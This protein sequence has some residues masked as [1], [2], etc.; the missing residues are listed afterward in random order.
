[1]SA[2]SPQPMIG[3][4]PTWP[5][6]L[7]WCCW[8]NCPPPGS[9]PRRSPPRR[10]TRVSADRIG[11]FKGRTP[12]I[13]R[14]SSFVLR[15]SS[16][17]P[18]PPLAFNHQLILLAQRDAGLGCETL[19]AGAHQG[20]RARVVQARGI[21][22]F[23]GLQAMCVTEATAP[24][25]SVRPSI[26]PASSSTTP[27]AVQMRAE[28]GVEDWV[29]L[30]DTHSSFDRIQRRST[31][32][33][34]GPTGLGGR[35]AASRMIGVKLGGPRAPVNND[36][37]W[38]VDP[39]V[40][41][42]KSVSPRLSAPLLLALKNGLVGRVA[43]PSYSFIRCAVAPR[44]W[45]LRSEAAQ[46]VT[47]NNPSVFP[48]AS[49]HF[50]HRFGRRPA[51]YLT[52]VLFQIFGCFLGKLHP[53]FLSRTDDQGVFGLVAV[54]LLDPPPG[55]G[56]ATCRKPLWRAVCCVCAPCR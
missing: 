24:A 49:F 26:I 32:C 12:V 15:P 17:I 6:C 44:P 29:V 30:H 34:N 14:R 35:S 41:R 5:G 48:S 39:S 27:F 45:Q 7:S 50:L 18:Q 38:H 11:R 47:W 8:W 33:Q 51:V 19:R 1:M 25:I 23:I 2:Y 36:P 54:Q 3:V 43:N 31:G 56:C 40:M 13:L 46:Q 55:R 22:G 28:A 21:A 53:V 20:S 52:A 16:L 37:C 4:S 42:R 9:P 10:W